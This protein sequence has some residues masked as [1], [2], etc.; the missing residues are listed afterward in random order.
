[1]D[2]YPIFGYPRITDS[3]RILKN[4][5]IY[6][7][8]I[9][10]FI[11][12]HKPRGETENLGMVRCYSSMTA[13]SLLELVRKRPNKFGL[14]LNR[15]VSMTTD[16]GGGKKGIMCK[17]GR[18]VKAIH[19]L[20]LAHGIHLAVTDILY[21]EKKKPEKKKSKVKRKPAKKGRE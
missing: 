14:D 12:V 4:R 18:I 3:F 11:N 17:L 9:I 2:V 19:Q 7:R 16:S 6:P 21:E 10:R 1:M 8:I 20:C 13:E 15:I 5:I